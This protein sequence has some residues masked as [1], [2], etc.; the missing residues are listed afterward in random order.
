[1]DG[2]V[3]R[4]R[5]SAHVHRHRAYQR[6]TGVAIALADPLGPES[7]RAQSVVDFVDAAQHAGLVPAFFSA[8]EATRDALPEGGAAS[9]S[10]TTRSSISKGC[11]SPA[12]A[13]TMCAPR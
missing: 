6:H 9:S 10:R 11:S 1:V 2:D 3:G 4:Q 12:N 7:G 5:L 8:S 13:G